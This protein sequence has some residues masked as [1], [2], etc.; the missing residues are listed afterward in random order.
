VSHYA[1]HC[2][3]ATGSAI[4]WIE[5][6]YN[7]FPMN[8]RRFSSVA[9]AVLLAAFS[10]G[11]AA[12]GFGS[13][14]S[15]QRLPEDPVPA[16]V[17]TPA[18]APAPEAEAS[19]FMTGPAPAAAAAE[20]DPSLTGSAGAAATTEA[21]PSLTGSAGAAA[22]T[23]ANPFL[24][25][26]AASAAAAAAETEAN[27]VMPEIAPEPAPASEATGVN[28]FLTGSAA[29]AAVAE[30]NPFLT[31]SAAAAVAAEAN[32]FL[33]GS[34]AAAA[35][36]E[37]NPLT[38]APAAGGASPTGSG[39]A[40]T[41]PFGSPSGVASPSAVE[42]ADRVLVKKSERRLYLLRADRVIA[43]YPIK[44]GLSPKGAKQREGDFRTPEGLYQIASRNVRSD[45][46]MSLEISYP[47]QADRERARELGVRPGGLIMIH[48]QPDRP[49]KPRGYY[50]NN[51]W[52]DGCI[53]VA[54]SDMADIWLRTPEGTPIEI[55]P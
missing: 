9:L 51:D 2:I 14:S 31:G 50:A 41:V 10:G 19:P 6:G 34:T 13:V 37:P 42:S 21:D 38:S 22:T 39:P 20:A 25:G 45:F 3:D 5:R 33:T 23:G 30:A 52:T 27:P 35:A 48:G 26:S 46:F 43:D 7:P 29:A 32:P 36:A 11:A 44:L 40:T 18:T 8:F 49:R 47:N 16:Q 55:R 24:T 53:A 17:Q 12:Q 1:R 15:G 54:N 4:H 28:P